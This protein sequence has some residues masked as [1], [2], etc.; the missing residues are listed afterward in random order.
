MA[1]ASNKPTAV[2]Y[3]LVVFVAFTIGLGVATYSF[4]RDAAKARKDAVDAQS[5][6]TKAETQWKALEDD[7]QAVKKVLGKPVDQVVVDHQNAA[8]PNTTVSELNREMTDV[9]R[10]LKEATY[11]GTLAKLR[12]A[13]D[14]ATSEREK[15]SATLQTTQKEL[16]ALQTR[17]AGNTDEHQKARAQAEADKRKVIDEVN[18]RIEAKDKEIAQ[19]RTDYN[20]TQVLLEQE[21]ESRAKERKQL[22]DEIANLTKINE[23]LREELDEIK[24]ESFEVADG[25]IRRVD[26]TARMVW[27]DL[28]DADFLK[29]RMTFSVY[30]KDTPGVGRSTADIKGKIEVTRIIDPHLAEAKMIEEDIFR[31]MAPGD[32]IYTPLWSPG[33]P[34]RFAVVG[35]VDLDGDGKSDRELFHQ[36]MAVRGAEIADEVDDNGDRTGGGINESIK[37]LILGA[38]PDI[39][40]VTLD[41]ERT[42]LQKV[43]DNLSEMRKEARMHGVRIIPLN[44]FL[45]YI[46]YKPKRRLFRPGQDRPYNL[47]AGAASTAVNE[48]L[49]ERASSG[50]VSGSFSRSKTLPPQTSSGTTSKLFGS[51]N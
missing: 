7:L 9:G 12:Q 20:E 1:A 2:H 37:F 47:K 17:Y 40:N 19:L 45:A 39:S 6:A 22:Q 36:E 51:G 11:S 30:A 21:K 5:K 49:G 24:R 41:E 44:D 8:N 26:N 50:Q 43:M 27:I 16:L 42:K 18:E 13:L 29:P 33:R 14:T 35:V 25:L 4:S 23:R 3:S 32:I 34:E 15:L 46:G 31:P 38:I 48:P 10:D 28:G